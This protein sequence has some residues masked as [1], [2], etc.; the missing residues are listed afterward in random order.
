LMKQFLISKVATKVTAGGVY[1]LFLLSPVNEWQW[2]RKKW[3]KRDSKAVRSTV[4]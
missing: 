2:A 4:H 3:T 1:N